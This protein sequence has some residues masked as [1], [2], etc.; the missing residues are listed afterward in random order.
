[1]ERSIAP[2]ASGAADASDTVIPSADTLVIVEDGDVVQIPD[3]SRYRRGQT[4]QVFRAEVLERA[5][6]AAAAAGDLSAT[7]DCSLVLRHVP[8]ARVIAVAGDEANMKITTRLD[9]VIADR[10][11]QMQMLDPAMV[12]E[13][14]RTL[15]DA[16][17]L[18]VGGTTGIGALVGTPGSAT[19]TIVENEFAAVLLNEVD[20]SDAR[21]GEGL[22]LITIDYTVRA[23]NTRYNMV[24]P[25]YLTEA[26][27]GV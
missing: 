21:A 6:E 3:R 19:L 13:P 20:V 23:T 18:V 24:Y 9:M 10:M 26:T 14:R 8:G 25:F 16:R 17:V 15:D 22:L 11:I 5:Y 7:D 27:P 12:L 2:V 1:V 4:P